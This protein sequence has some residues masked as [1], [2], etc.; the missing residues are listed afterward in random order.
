[1]NT[2]IFGGVQA[3]V[4]PGLTSGLIGDEGSSPIVKLP[5][6]PGELKQCKTILN[7]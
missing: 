7:L 3:G 2:V 1:M 6:D 5:D 4:E